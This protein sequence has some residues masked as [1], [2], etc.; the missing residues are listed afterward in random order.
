[1]FIEAKKICHK[2]EGIMCIIIIIN[3]KFEIEG[4]ASVIDN[5]DSFITE[6]GQLY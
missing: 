5:K 1:M 2:N 4:A 6:W 3:R